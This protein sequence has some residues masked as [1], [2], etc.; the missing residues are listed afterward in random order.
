MQITDRRQIAEQVA[1]SIGV[2]NILADKDGQSAESTGNPAKGSFTN[3][4]SSTLR[5]VL[6]IE[7]QSDRNRAIRKLQQNVLIW[8]PANTGVIAVRARSGDPKLAQHIAEKWI[9]IFQ[10]EYVRLT[11]T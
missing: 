3:W 2:E 7:P 9:D 8:S 4:L 11:H 5:T 6:R 1:D 10:Q